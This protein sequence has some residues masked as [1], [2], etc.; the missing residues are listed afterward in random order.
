[1][2]N[3]NQRK[4]HIS[5]RVS[6][7]AVPP[8]KDMLVLGKNSPIGCIAMR[9]ALE[10]LVKTPFEHIEME[11]DCISDI[12]VRQSMLLRI[13]KQELIEFVISQVKPMLGI[14]EVLHLELDINVFL[15]KNI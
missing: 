15:S 11:D 13:S 6:E 1:M 3:S 8:I 4:L 10:L 7:Y 5:A 9:R 2:D 12:L 14:D